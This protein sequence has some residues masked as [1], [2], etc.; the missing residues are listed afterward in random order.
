MSIIDWIRERFG[1]KRSSAE[2][3]ALTGAGAVAATSGDD[4]PD[5]RSQSDYGWSG[6]AGSSGDGGGAVGGG[7]DGGG[8]GAGGGG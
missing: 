2:Y 5:D 4:S 3:T 7:A 8:G 1:V 6:D